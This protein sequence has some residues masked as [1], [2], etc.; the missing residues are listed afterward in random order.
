MFNKGD[1]VVCF[2][3]KNLP[4]GI[5]F[6][7]YY[8]VAEDQSNADLVSLEGWQIRLES[9]MF[10]SIDS[11]LES[12]CNDQRRMKWEWILVLS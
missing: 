5:E 6:G 11:F 8:V 9:K 12:F 2:Y 3:T 7:K 4:V 10:C 1:V